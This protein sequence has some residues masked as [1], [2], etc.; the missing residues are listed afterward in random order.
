MKLFN[1]SRVLFTHLLILSALFFTSAFAYSKPTI[2]FFASNNTG[3][4]D[5]EKAYLRLNGKEQE[6][7][8]LAFIHLLQ[9]NH[10]EQGRLQPI[11]GTY[12][13]SDNQAITA[14]N[15]TVFHAS[16]Y[17]DLSTERSLNLARDLAQFL[18][19]ESVA[20]FIPEKHQ[21]ISQVIV[22]FK[23]S[24]PDIK[25]TLATINKNLPTAYSQAFSLHL[26]QGNISFE[27]AKVSQI[28][29]LGSQI[30]VEEVK[31]AFPLSEV[32]SRNG[33]AYLVYQNG[34]REIL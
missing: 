16:P 9:K 19:Q 30:N 34:Q 33:T 25:E 3:Q 18:K 21:P 14:D 27:E 32:N 4:I 20:V 26:K 17:Q 6:D 23:D 24:S 12:Q 7:L 29:W 15:T 13:L 8:E 2:D 10:F 31:K 22:K 5:L 28:Q 1:V 11:L